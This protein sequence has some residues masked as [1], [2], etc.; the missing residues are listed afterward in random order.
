MGGCL[1]LCGCA[2]GFRGL[3]E[4]WGGSGGSQG[5]PGCC[6]QP[7]QPVSSRRYGKRVADLK[8]CKEHAVAHRLGAPWGGHS[9]AGGAGE[10][11]RGPGELGGTGVTQRV[12]GVP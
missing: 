2:G 9:G 1:G 8:E 11:P 12:L 10:G 4:L 5:P 3:L 6:A 7:C